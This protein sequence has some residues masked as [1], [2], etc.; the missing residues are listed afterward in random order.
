MKQTES[1]KQEPNGENKKTEN[2]RTGNQK[3]EQKKRGNKIIR[4]CKE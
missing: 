3:I 1:M 2:G 4:K